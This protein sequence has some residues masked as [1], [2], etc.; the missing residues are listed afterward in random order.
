LLSH[1]LVIAS[2]GVD[3]RLDV[4]SFFIHSVPVLPV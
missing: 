1:V 2:I 4:K 3:D